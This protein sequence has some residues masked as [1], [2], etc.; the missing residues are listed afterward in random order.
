MIECICVN[1]KGKPKII[2]ESKWVQQG[3]TYHVVYTVTVLPQKELAFQLSEIEL[4]E[5]CLP[6]EYFLANRFAFDFENLKLLKQLIK[7]FTDTDFSINELMK[8]T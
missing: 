2:P 6:F 1:D 8:K 3:E 5:S 4:D 7:D